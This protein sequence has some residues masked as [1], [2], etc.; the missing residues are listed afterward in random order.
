MPLD[1]SGLRKPDKNFPAFRSSAVN[2]LRIRGQ[3]V[4][5]ANDASSK[6]ELL[7][8]LE[9]DDTLIALWTGNYST[10]A[11]QVSPKMVENWRAEY[12]K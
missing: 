8:E 10:D 12:G 11:F 7:R 5:Q 9:P 2:V 3:V 6:R 1:T 4:T